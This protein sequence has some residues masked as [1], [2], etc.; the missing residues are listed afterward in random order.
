MIIYAQ[1]SGDS[2]HLTFDALERHI[3]SGG[4]GDLKELALQPVADHGEQA[5]TVGWACMAML[6]IL[7]AVREL[8]NSVGASA[9]INAVAD[10]YLGLIG[11]TRT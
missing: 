5:D 8:T 11:Q 6:G 4:D 1:L 10:E 3:V 2:A 9:K 7:V